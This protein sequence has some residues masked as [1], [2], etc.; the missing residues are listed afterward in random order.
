[1]FNKSCRWLNS[2]P[3]PLV[4]EATALP[5]VQQT[6]PGKICYLSFQIIVKFF[7]LE[8]FRL[9]KGGQILEWG[10]IVEAGYS[11]EVILWSEVEAGLVEESLKILK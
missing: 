10:R 2:N 5:T 4:S 3:G 7:P 1:M 6:L 9:G 11:C 8:P